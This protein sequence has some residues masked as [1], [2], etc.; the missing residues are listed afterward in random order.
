MQALDPRDLLRETPIYTRRSDSLDNTNGAAVEDT[1]L[2]YP[3]L[4]DVP[5]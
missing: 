3:L 1:R 5:A 2:I 4:M